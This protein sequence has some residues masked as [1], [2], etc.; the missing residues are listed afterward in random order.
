MRVGTLKAMYSLVSSGVLAADLARHPSGAAVADI[1]DRVLVLTPAELTAL[2]AEP[3]DRKGARER[4]LAACVG[5]PRM[6]RLMDGVASSVSEGLPSVAETR[7]LVDALAETLLGGLPDLLD[8]LRTEVP[9]Q[10]ADP[11]AAQAALDAVAAAWS[12]RTADLRDLIVLRR[13]WDRALDPVPAALPQGPFAE[14]LR[15]LLD[16]VSRRSPAAW[17]ATL[18]EHS[19]RRRRMHW[20]TA[21]HTAC[22]AAFEADRLHDVARAQLAG[23]RAL[24]LSGASTGTE[25][26]ALAMAVSAAVQGTCTADLISTE[27]HGAL[28]ATWNAGAA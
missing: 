7:T 19:R 4:V 9:L 16:D 25:A 13:P 28:L 21:M 23:A 20:S 14:Q 3:D 27:C 8:L 22:Q 10:G 18:A 24:R 15:V 1:V 17:A 26:H 12:G 6:S 5:A 11:A 2:A